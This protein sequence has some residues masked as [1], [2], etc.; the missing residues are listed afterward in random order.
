LKHL[1][2]FNSVTFFR[3]LYYTWALCISLRMSN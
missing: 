3:T 1:A 2:L